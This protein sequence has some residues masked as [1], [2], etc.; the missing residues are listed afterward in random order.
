MK[1]MLFL[2]VPLLFVLAVSNGNAQNT[3]YL[4]IDVTTY[5][6]FSITSNNVAPGPT[7]TFPAQTTYGGADN[8]TN[9][10]NTTTWEYR[11]NVATHTITATVTKQA[12]P[13]NDIPSSGPNYITLTGEYEPASYTGTA[14][15]ADPPVVTLTNAT[16]MLAGVG[17]MISF[18]T[19]GQAQGTINYVATRTGDP[20]VGLY[21]L[22]ITY[23][24]AP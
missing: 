1:K 9:A 7:L 3:S 6:L 23:T 20:L 15:Y 12:G 21:P 5:T 22:V 8:T 19:V 13:G 2:L 10:N 4:Q 24:V 16:G 14:V 18:T 11:S 17:P